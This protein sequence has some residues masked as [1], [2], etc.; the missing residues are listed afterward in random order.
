[1]FNLETVGLFFFLF[2]LK[3]F[4]VSVLWCINKYSKKEETRVKAKKIQSVWWG[5]IVFDDLLF[6]CI[7]CFLEVGIACAVVFEM[8]YDN[9][10]S[11]FINWTLALIITLLLC[12][13]VPAVYYLILREIR[14]NPIKAYEGQFKQKFAGHLL[15]AKIDYNDHEK[16]KHYFRFIISFFVIRVVFIGTAFSLSKGWLQIIILI[17]MFSMSSCNIA[18][19]KPMQ[20]RWLNR[21][22]IFNQF[23]L[24]VCSYHLIS[25]TDYVDREMHNYMGF[26]FLITVAIF[27]IVNLLYMAYE[28]ILYLHYMILMYFPE[29]YVY[30]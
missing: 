22:A 17:V 6:L 18:H 20:G 15:G 16:S 29:I 24:L 4:A 10:D 7:R 19:M 25:F 14:I 28:L 13:G 5:Q 30:F 11:S 3:A 12:F 27:I 26:S 21:L 2:L 23:S 8:P 9:T 1:M